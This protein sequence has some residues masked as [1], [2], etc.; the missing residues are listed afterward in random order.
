MP[1]FLVFVGLICVVTAARNTHEAMG[2][3]LVKDFTGQKSFI[4]WA[5]A[6]GMVGV[7]GYASILKGFSRAFLGLILLALVL[8]NPGIFKAFIDAIRSGGVAPDSPA[9]SNSQSTFGSL[10]TVPN[11]AGSSLNGPTSDFF[12]NAAESITNLGS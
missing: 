2:K 10:V 12:G 9:S 5:A 6:I 1:F 4:M 8:R 7:L 11:L 3:Q